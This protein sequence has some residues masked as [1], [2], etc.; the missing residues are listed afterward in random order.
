MVRQVLLLVDDVYY[1]GPVGEAG[2]YLWDKNLCSIDAK[3][4][5]INW[6]WCKLD[7]GF[8]PT[9]KELNDYGCADYQEQGIIK[10]SRYADEWLIISYW[11]RSV[12]TRHNSCST[13]LS[14][15]ASIECANE[16]LSRAK[17]IYPSIFKRIKFELRFLG[18]KKNE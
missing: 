3:K 2:H 13:F 1:F 8:C 5:G 7:G 16:L 4:A 10:I 12:D 15:T 17:E 9:P 14:K 11:D 6:N 18:S